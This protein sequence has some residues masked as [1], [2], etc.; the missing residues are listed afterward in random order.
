MLTTVLPASGTSEKRQKENNC[1]NGYN[2]IVVFGFVIINAVLV[3]FEPHYG[4]H[5]FWFTP[6][7]KVTFIGYGFYYPGDITKFYINTFTNVTSIDGITLR[8]FH[9]S[10]HYQ[11]IIMF[12]T[13][14]FSACILYLGLY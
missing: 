9:V 6:V 13:R 12:P 1:M 8:P 11:H 3:S 2:F 5:E 4:F 10:Q 14:I 7:K